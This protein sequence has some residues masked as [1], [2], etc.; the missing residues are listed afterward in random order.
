MKRPAWSCAEGRRVGPHDH[1]PLH[2]PAPDTVSSFIQGLAPLHIPTLSPRLI[3]STTPDLSPWSVIIPTSK[4]M[5]CS[6]R[7]HRDR[8]K[9]FPL[10]VLLIS[11]KSNTSLTFGP[12]QPRK[13]LR[14]VEIRGTIMLYPTCRGGESVRFLYRAP[15]RA[16]LTIH[17]LVAMEDAHAAVTNLDEGKEDAESNAF[18][19]VYD[20]HGGMH[21]TL[22]ITT[23]PLINTSFKVLTSPSSPAK[24]FTSGSLPRNRTRLAITPRL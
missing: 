20:G 15:T 19:A 14:L 24:T 6:L 8:A 23:P 4:F 16:S 1:L 21:V 10:Q 3:Y 17:S 2:I 9:L 12:Q 11:L 18:F 13:T 22:L 7:D 5:H